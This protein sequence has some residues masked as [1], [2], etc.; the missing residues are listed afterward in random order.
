VLGAAYKKDIDDM[1]ESPSLRLIE[2][3]EREGAAV[4]FND[5]YVPKLYKMRKYNYTMSSVDLTAE[6]LA[7]YD[8]VILSTDH[9]NYDY[10]LIADNSSLIL[11]TRN[12][13]ER[14]GIKAEHIK[15]S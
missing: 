4:D 5:P 2:L 14:N 3:L 7:K 10:K 11:D 9:S 15:K 12:A 8:L 13:F 1:R 6:S